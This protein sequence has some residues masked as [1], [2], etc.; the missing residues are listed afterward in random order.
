M[1]IQV[2]PIWACNENA[3]STELRAQG[4]VDHGAFICPPIP[5]VLPLFKQRQRPTIHEPERGD[6]CPLRTGTSW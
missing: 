3:G 2:C 5:G 6:R 4:S 1:I